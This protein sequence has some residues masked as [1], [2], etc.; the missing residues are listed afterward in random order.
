MKANETLL[1]LLLEAQF[2]DQVPRSGYVLR[3]IADPES[4]TEHSWHV[5]FLVWVL[6][7]RIP[8][9][10][11][12]R[13]MGIAL[14]HDLAE[15]RLGDLPRTSARYF[16]EGAKEQAES[17][18]MAEILAPLPADAQALYKEYLERKTPESRLVKACD[19][20][21]L[22]IKVMVYEGWGAGGLAEFWKKEANFPDGEFE[23]VAEVVAAL[24]R[25]HRERI[26]SG[27]A[28]HTDKSG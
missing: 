5:L 27:R 28:S 13:A 22:M 20:L 7:A 15:V 12:Q 10:D 14:V 8:G 4:V 23:P 25:R 21:Q 3:G 18:A 1:D 26:E 24:R 2:L 9:L 17:A 6:G 19:K 11:V 16:P